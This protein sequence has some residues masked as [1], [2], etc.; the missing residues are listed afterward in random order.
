MKTP[1]QPR[2][3]SSRE[4]DFSSPSG[5]FPGWWMLAIA[6]AAQFMS[7]PGQSYSVAAYK[8]PMRTGLGISETDYSL[9]YGLATLLSGLCLPLVGRLVDRFGARRILPV[10]AILLGVACLWMSGADSLPDL[11]VGFGLIRSLGQGA[12][13]LIGMWIVGEWFATRRGFAASI[14]GLG[15]SLSVMCFPLMNN[16][17]ISHFGWQVAWVVLG[18]AVWVVLILPAV[19]VLRD[20]PEDLGLHPDGIAPGELKPAP[21]AG[22][23]DAEAP[24]EK[25]STEFS[26]DG[27]SWTVGEVLRDLTFWRLLAVP[28][29][30]GMIITGLT[31]HQVAMLGSRGVPPAW[32]LGMISVQALV[33]TLLSLPAG[34]LTDRIAGRR[35]LSLAMLLLAAAGATVLTMPVPQLALAYAALLGLHGSILRTT[36][37]VI[38]LNYYGRMNQGGIRGIMMSVMILAAA[39]GPL[40]MALSIDCFQSYDIAL[41]FFIVIPLTAAT[42]VW[43]AVPPQH[44]SLD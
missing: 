22:Q 13:T 40:P 21:V 27:P 23:E 31:F 16:Q 6:G 42:I 25:R 36:G 9:A 39:L 32:A 4:A 38:W 17:L 14:A 18:V 44:A 8:D 29:S 30:S 10:L 24:R 37:N 7:G 3:G 33:A 41:I 19:F 34:W 1:S 11:Y 20:R 43:T 2:D 5:I 26:L 15:G 28:A 12:L 35:L